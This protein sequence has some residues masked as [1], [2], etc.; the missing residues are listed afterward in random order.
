MTNSHAKLSQLINQAPREIQPQKELWQDIERQLDKAE[1]QQTHQSQQP[2]IVKHVAVASIALAVGLVASNIWQQ[3]AGILTP[4]E[5]SALLT[6]LAD[7]KDQHQQQVEL[8]SRQQLTNWQASTLASPLEKGIEQLRKA[9]EQIYQALRQ[10]PN[11]KELWQL[12]LWTQQREI[13]LLQQGQKLPVTT[14]PQGA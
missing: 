3:K 10:T 6:T 8:L 1:V 2:K 4:N 5:P 7:I 9:A 12:W 11:D 14:V 13:E